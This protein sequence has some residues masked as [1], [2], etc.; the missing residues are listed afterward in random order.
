MAERRTGFARPKDRSYQDVSL[1]AL[2]DGFSSKGTKKLQFMSKSDINRNKMDSVKEVTR[3]Q[4]DSLLSKR[5][6]PSNEEGSETG[7]DFWNRVNTLS[8]ERTQGQSKDLSQLFKREKAQL[9][10]ISEAEWESLPDAHA[11]R[12]NKKAREK[13]TPVPD[14]FI[15]GSLFNTPGTRPFAQNFGN[16]RTGLMMSYLDGKLDSTKG[17]DS[18]ALIRGGTFGKKSVLFG[19]GG[20]KSAKHLPQMEGQSQ[21]HST[22]KQVDKVGY[23]TKLNTQTLIRADHNIQDIKKARLL[24][25]SIRETDPLN[26]QGYLGGARVEVIDGKDDIARGL[27]RKGLEKIPTSEDIWCEFIRL[28]P[29]GKKK[30]RRSDNNEGYLGDMKNQIVSGRARTGDSQGG[31]VSKLTLLPDSASLIP[32]GKTTDFDVSS[33]SHLKLKYVQMGLKNNPKSAKLWKI[34]YRLMKEEGKGRE[35]LKKALKHCT[36]DEFLWKESVQMALNDEE[37]RETLRKGIQSLPKCLDFWI[38]L[39]KLSDYKAAKAVLREANKTFDKSELK[40]YVNGAML[41]EANANLE[42]TSETIFKMNLVNLTKERQKEEGFLKNVEEVSK[43]LLEKKAKTSKKILTLM[44]KGFKKNLEINNKILNRELWIDEAVDCEAS[45]YPLCAT[46]IMDLIFRYDFGG[47]EEL[48]LSFFQ[49]EDVD[50]CALAESKGAVKSKTKNLLLRA[51]SRVQ[52]IRDKYKDSLAQDAKDLE[53]RGMFILVQKVHLFG[54]QLMKRFSPFLDFGSQGIAC[55][56]FWMNNSEQFKL[57][58]NQI[59]SKVEEEETFQKKAQEY[60]AQQHLQVSSESHSFLDKMLMFYIKKHKMSLVVSLMDKF[61]NNYKNFLEFQK[62][63]ILILERLYYSDRIDEFSFRSLIEFQFESSFGNV[64]DPKCRE[65]LVSTFLGYASTE[66]PR[67]KTL[68]LM[69]T[70]SHLMDS[71]NFSAKLL[72]QRLELEI[73]RDKEANCQTALSIMKAVCKRITK[74]FK[75]KAQDMNDPF[76]VTFKDKK[77]QKD[78]RVRIGR[79]EARFFKIL[80]DIFEVRGEE[81]LARKS[82]NQGK[83]LFPNNLGIHIALLK[84]LYKRGLFAEARVQ[85]EQT[86][87]R[88]PSSERL[89][90]EIL[91]YEKPNKIVYTNLLT[92]AK[93]NCP[94]SGDIA[95]LK[96][97]NDSSSNQKMLA[98]DCAKKF[99]NCVEIILFIARLFF[100]EGKLAKSKKWVMSAWEAAPCNLDLLAFLY[101][102]YE[103]Q[104]DA[105]IEMRVLLA[106]VAKIRNAEGVLTARILEKVRFDLPSIQPIK[107]LF[108]EVVKKLKADLEDDES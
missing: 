8:N 100:S 102:L 28:L 69:Q 68:E 33:N 88:F 14:Q 108:F 5:Q 1:S 78:R 6:A 107:P 57:I 104:M 15:V 32:S 3:N 101:I 2:K 19:E 76:E 29:S 77:S 83:K 67:E 35:A 106:K 98:N 11:K 56:L 105:Q 20:L 66:S 45:G 49:D 52:E 74:K 23:L 62:N 10:M 39:A 85:F 48:L 38:A 25:K 55:E 40:I 7:V 13:S 36:S 87:R 86:S 44:S 97:S 51:S 75:K 4:F 47:L 18:L 64:T 9:K 53:Q 80:S 84:L 73:R 61:A 41:E 89:Y 46:T 58:R 43:G 50:F 94:F 26:E 12:A 72:E 91:P 16:A 82:L 30:G 92:K 60:L 37:K 31:T 70:A 17:T 81:D 103:K 93:K 79:P 63:N 54:E 95:I 22:G 71:M 96:V 34:Y 27:L 90:L 65:F 24:L 59:L 21:S 42:L 99:P